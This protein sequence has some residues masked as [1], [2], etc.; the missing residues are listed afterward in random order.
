MLTYELFSTLEHQHDPSS[1]EKFKIDMGIR[2]T[3]IAWGGF[4]GMDGPV[5]DELA[6]M[7][8]YSGSR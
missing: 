5:E 4:H 6:V 3:V 2:W 1:I 8:V 7:A